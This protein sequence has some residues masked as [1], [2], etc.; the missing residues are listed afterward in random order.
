MSTEPRPLRTSSAD[1]I[2]QRV[3]SA[4]G[5]AIAFDRTGHGAPLILVEAAGHYRGLS[6]FTGLRALLSRTFTVYS[7]DRRGRGESADTTPFAPNRE[8]DDLAALIREA[9]G[10]AAMYGYSS[11][12][13]LALRAAAL[14]LPIT[15]LAVLEPPLRDD[16]APQPDPLT[17]TLAEMMEQGRRGDVVE[18]FHQ[19]IG[20]PPEV[21]AEMRGT[22]RWSQIESIAHTLV[23]DCM[24]SDAMSSALLRDVTVPTLV[25]DS[26]GSSD[27]LTGWA[28][29]V[30]SRLPNA[31]HRSLPGEWHTVADDVL[32][33]VLTEFFT[34]HSTT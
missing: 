32:A 31:R 5:T 24:L 3:R 27:D 1:A 10:T 19:N 21:I 29:T 12:A 23:Y 9:G 26:E 30:A 15:R 8:V 18:H 4:D 14:K 7:Y 33:P 16:G 25:L 2:T 22:T 13:L 28:A 20:V 17:S 34:T 11:G 6:S